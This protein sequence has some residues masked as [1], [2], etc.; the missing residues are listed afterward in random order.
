MLKVDKSM[1]RRVIEFRLIVYTNFYITKCSYNVGFI[2]YTLTAVIENVKVFA[3]S[4]KQRGNVRVFHR[5]NK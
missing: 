5:L 2:F 1:D 4:C 3:F